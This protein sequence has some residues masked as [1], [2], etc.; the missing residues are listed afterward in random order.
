M[1]QMALD[2]V[3]KLFGDEYVEM[4]SRTA[5]ETNQ[6]E[7][8]TDGIDQ[9]TEVQE[10]E[11]VANQA[12]QPHSSLTIFQNKLKLKLSQAVQ[13]P[14]SNN[15][16]NTKQHLTKLVKQE[17]SCYEADSKLGTYLEK[18]LNALKT[19]PPTSTE[20]ERVFS[21][22]SNFCTK[23]RSRLS[24]KSLD[25]LCFLKSYFLSKSNNQK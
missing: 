19:I 3:I 9:L 4:E 16:T 21:M 11:V 15:G 14:I 17:L 20:S 18:L 8:E 1:K 25:A 7:G 5:I 2:L 13:G 22:S 24:D 6:A 10:A 12:A 23:K